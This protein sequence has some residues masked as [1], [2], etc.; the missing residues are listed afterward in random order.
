MKI[1]VTGGDGRLAKKLKSKNSDVFITPSKTE[2]DLLN[3]N[4]IKD[5]VSM[6]PNVN[7]IILNATIRYNEL[8]SLTTDDWFDVEVNNRL[9][10]IFR[11]NVL[12]SSQLTYSYQN[13]L[14]FVIGLTTG[15]IEPKSHIDCCE[16]Y[17]LGKDM[18]SSH[19][20][21]LSNKFKDTT[22][23]TINP[24]PMRNEGDFDYNANTLIKLIENINECESGK[25][26]EISEFYT[27][28]KSL[29]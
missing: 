4:S 21:R 15:Y 29:M 7:G 1:L 11:L 26:Y 27:S 23:L 14:K 12:A 28:S 19:L 25:S 2:L 5:I 3:P 17:I 6:Y 9:I 10:E 18:L 20:Y 8:D 24:G 22:I 16:S 13:S